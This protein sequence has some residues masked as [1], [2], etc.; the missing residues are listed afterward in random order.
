ATTPQTT[1]VP[2]FWAVFFGHVVAVTASSGCAVRT[3][4]VT[5]VSSCFWST[6]VTAP[7]PGATATAIAAARSASA[8]HSEATRRD[9]TRRVGRL[10]ALGRSRLQ[11]ERGG[12]HAVA[13]PGWGGA[14]VEHVAEVAPAPPAPDFGPVHAVAV[15]DDE[16]DGVGDHRLGEARPPGPRV[17]LRRRVEE[18]GTAGGARSEERRVGEEEGARGAPAH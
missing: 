1:T 3:A 2:V 9:T 11:L 6:I 14:V 17:E 10:P 18:R 7:A 13:L 16:L 8:A 15:V 5:A 4:D 12:V